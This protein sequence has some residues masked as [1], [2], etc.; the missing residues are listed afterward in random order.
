MGLE[1]ALVIVGVLIAIVAMVSGV[2]SVW[3]AIKYYR[4]NRRENSF[5]FT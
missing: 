1:I 5:D 4:F 3:L 2:V